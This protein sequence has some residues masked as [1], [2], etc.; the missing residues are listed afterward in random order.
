M[1]E[2]KIFDKIYRF[3]KGKTVIII[4]Y[5]FST[6]RNAD[7]IIVFDKGRI[8]EQG[9]HEELVALGGVYARAFSLQAEGYTKNKSL[10]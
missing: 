2:K 7:R 6:V 8:V 9:S 5:R 1:S 3:F 10:K 4:S